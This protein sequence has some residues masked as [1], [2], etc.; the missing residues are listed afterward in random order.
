VLIVFTLIVF[1]MYIGVLS[2]VYVP[3]MVVG[4]IRP[5]ASVLIVTT[6]LGLVGSF[7]GQVIRNRLL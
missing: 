1:P 5:L 3:V 6:P 7:A 4:S 2:A